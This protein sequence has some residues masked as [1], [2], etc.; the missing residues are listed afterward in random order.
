MALVDTYPEGRPVALGP[1]ALDTPLNGDDA[2]RQH[3][4]ARFLAAVLAPMAGQSPW[5]RSAGCRGLPVALVVPRLCAGCPV[6]LPCLAAAL[7]EEARAGGYD[8]TC[9]GGLDHPERHRLRRRA[10][11]LGAITAADWLAVAEL[12][13][14]GDL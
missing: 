9:R 7:A 1:R 12:A 4:A 10:H 2:G 5:W 11:D 13:L 14:D 3:C 8:D 6:R